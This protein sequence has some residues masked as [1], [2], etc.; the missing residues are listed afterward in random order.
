[1]THRTFVAFGL[2]GGKLVGMRSLANHFGEGAED[3]SEQSNSL[4]S[5]DNLPALDRGMAVERWRCIGELPRC[6]GL[7]QHRESRIKYVP[8]AC[9]VRQHEWIGRH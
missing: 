9:K 8:K 4:Y 7:F 3:D 6:I 2:M 1:M 5:L